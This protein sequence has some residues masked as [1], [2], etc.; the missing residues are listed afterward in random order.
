MVLVKLAPL[1]LEK[2][3]QALSR[4]APSKLARKRMVSRTLALWRLAL[5]RS[6]KASMVLERLVL[7]RLVLLRLALL[8]SVR[9]QSLRSGCISGCSFLHSF[10]TSLP[11]LSISRCSWFAID[12]TSGSPLVGVQG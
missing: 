10:Q 5:L 6:V 1:R 11:C 2:E 9:L 8:N 7:L 4:L 3:K 12:L